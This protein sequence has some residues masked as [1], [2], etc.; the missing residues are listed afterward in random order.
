M[1][2]RRRR[3]AVRWLA[4]VLVLVGLAALVVAAG[5]AGAE[6]TKRVTFR[7]YSV[8]VPGS[9]PVIDLG[10]NPSTCVRFDVHAVYLGHPG[11]SPS[12]PTE[13][14]G[15]T[16]ALLVEPLDQVSRARVTADTVWAPRGTA[17]ATIPTQLDHEV[18]LGVSAAGVLVTAS[19]GDD[20][21]TVDDALSGATL[22]A[23]AQPTAEVAP[24]TATA[25]VIEPG[26][27]T[28]KGFDA[29]TAPSSAAMQAWLSSPYRALGVYIGGV[30]RA[31][32]QPNL[33]ASWVSAQTTQGWKL[34]PTYVGLQAPCSSGTTTQKIDP[35]SAAAQGRAAADD[36]VADA[37]PLG[38]SVG[39]VV[40]F[41]MEAYSDDAACR[42]AV[43]AFLS[44]WT[45]RLHELAYLSGVYS[46]AGSGI[47]DLVSVYDSAGFASPDHVWFAR[48]DGVATVSD[49]VIPATYWPNHQ[50]LKQYQGDHN[51][52]YGGVTINIDNDYLDVVAGA[53]QPVPAP[54]V[55][56]GDQVVTLGTEIHAF[57]RGT[58]QRLYETLYRPGAGWSTWAPHGGVSIAG[59]PVAVP[60]GTGF[61]VFARGTDS[62]LYE[63]YYRPGSGWSSWRAHGGKAIAGDPAVVTYGT[64]MNVFA[65]GTDSRLYEIYYRSSSGW[66]SWRAHGGVSVAGDP[67]AIS[68]GSGS[69]IHVLARG[70]DQLLYEISYRSGLGWSSW[71]SHAGVSIA[72]PPAVVAYGT[73][74]NLFARGT[75]QGLYEIYYRPSSGWSKWAP[76][77][78]KAIAGDP[79]AML[80][81]TEIHVFARGGDQLLYEIAYRPGL[82]WS[83]WTSHPGLSIA[84]TPAAVR[85]NYDIHVFA[86]SNSH[87]YETYFRPVQGWSGWS[88]KGGT[89]VQIT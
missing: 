73:G 59:N 62:R 42:Q 83:S 48:W 10:R 31:C 58:D 85:Y 39:S 75:N 45:T 22:Q 36:A 53:P 76:H 56:T 27:F 54:P 20:L 16:E 71:A 30:N 79:A 5:S 69:E 88:L 78:G 60:F 87:L 72:G 41:D 25:A 44:N 66:S 70:A 33:T 34:V 24:A 47:R 80:Y 18:T 65:R 8:E 19:Y 49:P 11:P 23:D 43:L 46:S 63:I 26:T 3:S 89:A 82:G 57:A 13:V 29:C 14:V 21:A 6:A 67:V 55:T 77:G 1:H 2:A 38:I 61:N 32:A 7:G 81:G 40:Y 17:A 52:S 86:R 64:G 9:W 4:V 12:C 50:R 37:G 28:G 51:E 15:R 84:G 68:L 35:L 74:F